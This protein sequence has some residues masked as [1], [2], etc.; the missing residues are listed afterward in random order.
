MVDIRGRAV[1]VLVAKLCLGAPPV[2]QAQDMEPRAYANA[3]VGLNF[4]IAGYVYTRG[5]VAFDNLPVTNPKLTTSSAILAYGRVLDLWGK[6]AKLNVIVPY[7]ALS[8]TAEV[9][10]RCSTAR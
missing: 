7:S 8:G 2:A 6:S 4:L 10:A 9:A 5:G 1:L 3:P